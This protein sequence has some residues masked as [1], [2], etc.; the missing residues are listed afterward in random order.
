MS[1]TWLKPKILDWQRKGYFVELYY[2]L[3][4]D[5]E[6]AAARVQNRVAHGGD[7]IPENVIRRR[8]MRSLDLLESTYKNLDDDWSVYDCSG[9]EVKLL[10]SKWIR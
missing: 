2:L 3:L 4:P 7:G 1:G 5:S 10:E 9:T 6:M 8:F